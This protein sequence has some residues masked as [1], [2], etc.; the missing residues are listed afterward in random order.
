[1][2][3]APPSLSGAAP[4]E[5]TRE[6]K[7]FS[8]VGV[9]LALLLGALD[10]TVVATAGPTIQKKLDIAPSMYAW[11]TT[12]YLVSSTV[13]VPVWGRLSDMFGRKK[14]LIVGVSLFLVASVLCGLAQNVGQ[15]I[16]FRALQGMGS[17]SLFTSAFAVVADLFSPAERGKYSGVIGSVFG[18]ASIIGPLL[19]GFITDRF[20]W[21][22]VFFINL[23]IGAIA[24]SF[25]AM[26][27]PALT[28]THA[29][30]PRIDYLGVVLLAAGVVPILLGLSFARVRLLPN[31]LGYLWGSWQILALFIFGIVCVVLFVIWE[32]RVTQPLINLSLFRGRVFSFGSA[33]TFVM[34]AVF[35][36]P[37]IF[38]PLYMVN[39]LGVSSTRAG[40]A[41]LPLVGGILI[42]NIGSGQLVSRLGRYKA[43]M[44]GGL[45]IL[46]VGLAVMSF[47]LTPE[48]SFGAVTVKM[49]LVGL[50]LGPT[51]PLYTIAIQNAV[52]VDQ[53]G[54][55]TSIVTF[56]RQMGSTIG[57]AIAGTVFAATLSSGVTSRLGEGAMAQF[58]V[59]AIEG[60]AHRST[61]GDAAKSALNAQMQTE[62]ALLIKALDGDQAAARQISQS[63]Y[64]DQR[65]KTLLI[66]G[67]PRGAVQKSFAAAW[68]RVELSAE[69]PSAW[70]ALGQS[71][72][73]P[74]ELA[75]A[76]AAT[77][78]ASLK[79]PGQR[80]QTLSGLR[81]G[82]QTAQRAAEDRAV[83]DA[84]VNLEKA[85]AA[86]VDQ[87]A[88]VVDSKGPAIKA[89]FTD[90]VAA[91]YRF[92]LLLAAV[93]FLLTLM[94]PALPLRGK[95]SA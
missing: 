70:A 52:P 24:L 53:L 1:M 12:A 65:L 81:G 62:R 73:I 79:D 58:S 45:S 39:V 33:T 36:S 26:R 43:L 29:V 89:A 7:I 64:V 6:Q 34:G 55:A 2:S 3:T 61:E 82:L 19:G 77:P 87:S 16:A 92:A 46:L 48:S 37:I 17:A 78:Y 86:R 85:I 21:H 66:A 20:G 31:E 32:R 56:F 28:R 68:A 49:V 13:L 75:R 72:E 91:T 9:L 5:L 22:W 95:K 40:I 47:T 84:R 69:D 74:V 76:V 63:P 8:F 15:L 11:I 83:N 27:M 41:T 10:Q 25:I 23:P 90:A 80:T 71:T 60:A 94:I 44:L 51:I 14:V 38:L 93:A 54:S 30:K 88:G 59:S 50:G 42:G 35:L 4:F 18:L 67:G 57:V